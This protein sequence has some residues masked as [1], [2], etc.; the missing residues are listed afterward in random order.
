[1]WLA[2]GQSV[3]FSRHRES[4]HRVAALVIQFKDMHWLPQASWPKVL[5]FVLLMGI[6]WQS[7]LQVMMRFRVE[8]Y[9]SS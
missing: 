1:V 6:Y 2:G 5:L 4:A 9:Y 3:N 8:Q 7:L